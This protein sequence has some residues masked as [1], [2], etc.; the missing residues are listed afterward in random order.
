LHSRYL[1]TRLRRVKSITQNYGENEDLD[2]KLEKASMITHRLKLDPEPEPCF[3]ISRF[4]KYPK[5]CG[6]YFRKAYDQVL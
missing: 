5:Y 6:Y 4:P 1:A 3:D 2:T